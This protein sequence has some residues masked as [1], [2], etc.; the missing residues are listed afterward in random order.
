MQVTAGGVGLFAV[1]LAALLLLRAGEDAGGCCSQQAPGQSPP[2]CCGASVQPWMRGSVETSAGEVPR[3]SRRWSL[4]DR[5]GAL[6]V[7]LG[8]GRM[9][10]RVEPGL[11]A[12]GEPDEECPVFVSANYKLSFDHLRTALGGRDGWILVLDTRGI[13]VW[14]AAGKGTF[15]TEEVVRR[16]DE[17]GLTEVVDHRRL[18]LPQLGAPG[19][20]AHEVQRRTGFSVTYGPVRAEDLPAFL[21]SGMEASPEMRR[22]RFGLKDRLVLVP[23]EVV[24][25][26]KTFALPALAVAALIGLA[27]GGLDASGFLTNAGRALALLV[28]A[29]LAGAALTPALLPWI[30]GRA[31]SL[32]GAILGAVPAIVWGAAAL[33]DGAGIG[34]GLECGGWLVLLPAVAAF[35]AMNFTGA[36]T[37]TSLSGVR[38]EMRIAV[39][40]QAAGAVLGLV[41]LFTG[42]LIRG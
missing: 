11:Y 41:L 19:V 16:A 23:V 18:V 33:R 9:D 39:P 10:Y 1:V 24:G 32:K 42:I 34:D 35:Y 37:Y 36:S 15:G 2:C 40:L 3:V 7:R 30:P 27:G 5:L 21:D 20:A 14:C 28:S 12:A 31:F 6:A 17:A 29:L 26:A 4:R 25:G 8:I 38:R 22:V 13:N